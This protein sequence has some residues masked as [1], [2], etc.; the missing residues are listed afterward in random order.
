VRFDKLSG[1]A[2]VIIGHVTK[3]GAIAGPRMLE[4]L[5]DTVLYFEREAGSRD[6]LVRATTNRF[7]AA[8]ELGFLAMSETV[9]LALERSTAGALAHRLR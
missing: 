8:H 1:T 7:G 2:V 4:H 3:E 5:V 6:R 9:G